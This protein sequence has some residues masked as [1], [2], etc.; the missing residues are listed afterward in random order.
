MKVLVYI[1]KANQRSEQELG[2]KEIAELYVESL[3]VTWRE[4]N[5]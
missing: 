1:V 5:P 3:V 2:L 4:L